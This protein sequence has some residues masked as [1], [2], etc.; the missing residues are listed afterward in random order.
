LRSNIS[1]CKAAHHVAQQ[2]ITLRSNISRCAATY[3]AAKQHITLQSSLSQKKGP[4]KVPFFKNDLKCF[5]LIY[6]PDRKLGAPAL[7]AGAYP[8]SFDPVSPGFGMMHLNHQ[9]HPPGEIG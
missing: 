9:N 8:R 4:V 3:H 2:H 7:A 1:R 5:V 6:L